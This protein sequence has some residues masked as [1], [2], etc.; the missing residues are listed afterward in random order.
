MAYT[1]RKSLLARVRAGDEISWKEFYATYEPL[2]RLCGSDHYL[3]NDEKD[4]LLQQVMAE[5]FQKDIIGKYDPDK[6]PDDVV[7]KFDPSKG[8]FRHYLR[9]IIHNQA[10]CIYH[11]RSR[12]TTMDDL[13]HPVI[14]KED[15]TQFEWDKKWDDEWKKHVLSQALTELRSKVQ[16]ETYAAFEMY[17]VQQRNVQTVADFLN[18]SVASVYTAKNRCINALKEIITTLEER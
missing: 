1:T 8:R 7:F 16:P 18:L 5:I 9:K 15:E 2:I 3:T 17:A 4:E 11:K 14:Q 10:L 12:F 13:E 6:I